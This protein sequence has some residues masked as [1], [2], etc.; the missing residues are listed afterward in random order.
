MFFI[1]S[2]R[3]LRGADGATNDKEPFTDRFSPYFKK[4]QLFLSQE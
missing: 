1:I 3:V 4:Y 2:A